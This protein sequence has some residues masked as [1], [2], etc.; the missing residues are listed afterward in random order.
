[1]EGDEFEWDD[2]KARTNLIKHD[3]SFELARLVFDDLDR[4]ERMD[5]DP[6]EERWVVMGLVGGHVLV[7]AYTERKVRRRIISARKANRNEQRR[8]FARL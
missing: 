7:V 3:V 2:E 1:M 8:Y 6:D 5:E 4:Q